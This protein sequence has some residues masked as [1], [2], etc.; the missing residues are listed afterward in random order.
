MNVPIVS[1][2][3]G[4]REDFTTLVECV[5]QAMCAPEEPTPLLQV[6]I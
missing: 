5:L 4:A 3:T 6:T 2:D 1:L